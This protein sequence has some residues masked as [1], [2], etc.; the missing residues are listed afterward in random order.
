MIRR[1]P[2]STLFPY[3]TLFRS[4]D[5]DFL[6]R[7]NLSFVAK[8]LERSKRGHRRRRCLLERHVAGF[9]DDSA[10]CQ[11]ADILSDGAVFPAENFVAGLEVR[12]V[13]ANCFDGSGIVDTQASVLW[14]AQPKQR[15]NHPRA[16]DGE[17]EWIH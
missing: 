9:W 15:T 2:R 16:A 6:A 13:L 12:D 8:A 5:Q 1:P 10:I 14:F 17:V 4:V 7:L 11:S 3:T